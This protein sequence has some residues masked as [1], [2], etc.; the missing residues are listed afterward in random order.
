TAVGSIV[1]W[2]VFL[3]ALR[4]VREMREV[5]REKQAHRAAQIQEQRA[6][7]LDAQEERIDRKIKNVIGQDAETDE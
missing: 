6:R 7:E 1:C 2:W 4:L 5:G 3:R